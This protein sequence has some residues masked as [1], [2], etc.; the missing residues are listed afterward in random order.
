MVTQTR[1][2][3]SKI[4]IENI[5]LFWK[6]HTTIYVGILWNTERTIN[7]FSWL[8]LKFQPKQYAWHCP[9][10]I[11]HEYSAFFFIFLFVYDVFAWI[12]FRSSSLSNT[13][14]YSLRPSSQF[15]IFSFLQV[16]CHMKKKVSLWCCLDHENVLQYWTSFF[17]TRKTTVA[18]SCV[19]FHV[20]SADSGTWQLSQY[21][22][23]SYNQHFC[24]RF[25]L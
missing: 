9:Y 19:F 12:I 11:A 8:S 15:I 24:N 14:H 6:T 16:C 25:I 7:T 5:G 13:S 1:M 22:R 4:L 17:Y 23:D 18:G 10:I 21:C 20:C 3:L 2:T